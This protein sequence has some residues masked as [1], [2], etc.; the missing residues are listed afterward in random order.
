MQIKKAERKHVKRKRIKPPVYDLRAMDSDYLP[1]Y[2]QVY[3][4]GA[5]E[6]KYQLQPEIFQHLQMNKLLSKVDVLHSHDGR[7]DRHNRYAREYNQPY[8]Q[9]Y[10]GQGWRRAENT[11]KPSMF[12]TIPGQTPRTNQP[13]KQ[14]FK[15]RSPLPIDIEKT[16]ETETEKFLKTES[17]KTVEF[18]T[19]LQHELKI[20]MKPFVRP[21]V[22][23]GASVQ[24]SDNN[25]R[26]MDTIKDIVKRELKESEIL[27]EKKWVEIFMGMDPHDFT[28][29]NKYIKKPL[30]KNLTGS[31]D[32]LDRSIMYNGYILAQALK[33]FENDDQ[34]Y[35]VERLNIYFMDKNSP[36][37]DKDRSDADKKEFGRMFMSN[38]LHPPTPN[39]ELLSADN[40]KQYVHNP[41]LIKEG[42]ENI[43]PTWSDVIQDYT[44]WQLKNVKGDGNCQ[45]HSIGIAFNIPNDPEFPQFLRNKMADYITAMESDEYK[46]RIKDFFDEIQFT[47]EEYAR[48]IRTNNNHWGDNFSLAM[49]ANIF[50][51][52]FIIF[53]AE[54]TINGKP[55]KKSIGWVTNDKNTDK[56]DDI[57]IPLYLIPEKHYMAMAKA[58]DGILTSV[59]TYEDVESL[60]LYNKYPKYS[61][62]TTNQKKIK[63]AKK[64]PKQL[65]KH[66]AK[67]TKRK[68]K[69]RPAKPRK[70]VKI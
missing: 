4:P 11:V 24:S 35:L 63:R 23:P 52:N 44:S 61:T 69:K 20:A 33:A 51:I 47:Q 54:G 6:K 41:Q 50:N 14:T 49:L 29:I 18:A 57:W 22:T 15:K 53:I 37:N 42:W 16:Q 58:V 9:P 45:Y 28:N 25:Q 1:Q 27:D 31:Q 60:L 12:Q 43:S 32:I 48:E 46:S 2:N 40:I 7:R 65:R 39:I 19:K 13:E 56:L 34:D 64:S 30:Q 66:A 36:W 17:S 67:T 62:T 5:Y 26:F 59:L 3:D 55:T 10:I 70:K 8:G 38:Y 68:T 21:S